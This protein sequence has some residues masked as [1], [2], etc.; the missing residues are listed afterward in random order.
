VCGWHG[1]GTRT[2]SAEAEQPGEEVGVLEDRQR[3]VRVLGQPLRHVGDPRAGVAA[4]AGAG[5]VAA[6]HLDAPFLD[7]AGTGDQRQQA[8]L[9][10]AVRP[11]QADRAAGRQVE[12]DPVEGVGLAVAEGD[13]RTSRHRCPV[14]RVDVAGV[15]SIHCG[16][17]TSRWAGHSACGS[18]RT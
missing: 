15:G 18:S 10:D 7:A 5:H 13:I 2:I 14:G 17:L 16:S 3:R 1:R 12:G 9:V 8:G 6:E 11:D 4:A